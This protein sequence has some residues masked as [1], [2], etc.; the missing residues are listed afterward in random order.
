MSIFRAAAL[1]VLLS[2]ATAAGADEGAESVIPVESLVP[3]RLGYAFE[4]PDILLRQRIFGQAYAV[5]LLVS[6][7]LDRDAQAVATQNAYDF[8]HSTQ[9]DTLANISA[10]L[11]RHHFDAEAERAQW[12][13]I[14]KALG[15]KETIYPSL[16][17]VRLEE[18]CASLPEALMQTRY[19]FAAQIELERAPPAAPP[20]PSIDDNDR[21]PR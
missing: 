15:L 8:W 16:G 3:Q 18:A 4:Q 17:V 5:H 20:A 1:A 11:A 14:A 21:A 6:A 2:A 13:D 12:L 10:I 19:D 9:H 7:C